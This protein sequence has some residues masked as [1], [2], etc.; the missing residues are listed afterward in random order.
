MWPSH[1]TGPTCR[2][3][4]QRHL[5]VACPR[6][7]QADL[8]DGYELWY[9]QWQ[10]GGPK[11]KP[12][13]IEYRGL[14]FANSHI[15]PAPPMG[16]VKQKLRSIIVEVEAFSRRPQVDSTFWADHFSKSLALL[17]ST[18]PVPPYHP[19]ILPDSGF[20][21]ETRQVLAAAMQAYVFG[22]MGS[23]NDMGFADKNL[24][25]EYQKITKELYEAVNMSIVFASNSYTK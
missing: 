5:P 6:A 17:D 23:W 15:Y 13:F 8:P 7:I 3:M 24:N 25:A 21:L 18:E 16:L 9:P 2:N 10:T 14:L 1:G 4:S 11:D 20:D 22:G 19:D 12:W